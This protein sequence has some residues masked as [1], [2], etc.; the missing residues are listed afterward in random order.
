MDELHRDPAFVARE[1][2]RGRQTVENLARYRRAAAPVLA[3]LHEAGYPVDSIGELREAG[4]RYPG[5]IPILLHWLP[6]ISDSAVKEDIVRTLSVPWARPTAAPVL[7]E[8]FRNLPKTEDPTGTA[9]HWAI[10]NALEVVAARNVLDELIEIALDRR[11]GVA[12]QM[13]VLALARPRDARVVPTL[14]SLLDDADVAGHAAMALGR[15]R[16]EVARGPLEALAASTPQAWVR[17]EAER[18]LAKISS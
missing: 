13:V 16:A 11:H 6:R 3:E 1:R 5:A 4:A 18:A 10:G 15:L 12:R 17:T 7:I 2:D 14:V 8:E 9:L